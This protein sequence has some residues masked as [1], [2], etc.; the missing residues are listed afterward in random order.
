MGQRIQ[1]IAYEKKNVLKFC[2]PKFGVLLPKLCVTVSHAGTHN[3]C[4]C[5]YHQNIK[6]FSNAASLEKEYYNLNENVNLLTMNLSTSLSSI[7]KDK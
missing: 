6:L 7:D 2:E 4:I 5:I 1:Q 3:V